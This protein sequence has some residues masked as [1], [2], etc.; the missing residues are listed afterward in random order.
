LASF[1]I[2]THLLWA[3]FLR[4]VKQKLFTTPVYGSGAKLLQ[5]N[6]LILKEIKLYLISATLIT[7]N[8]LFT[9]I[10]ISFYFGAKQSQKS[11]FIIFICFHF[12]YPRPLISLNPVSK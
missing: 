1:I 2:I 9:R 6:L 4:K 5:N 10:K 7:K 3:N 12:I 8:R 11:K